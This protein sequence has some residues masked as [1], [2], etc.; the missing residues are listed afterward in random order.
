MMR[1]PVHRLFFKHPVSR[2][3]AP[4]LENIAPIYYHFGGISQIV[5]KK[6]NFGT[7]RLKIME[8]EEEGT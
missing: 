2:G 7:I 6:L 3:I 4:K 1:L 8:H 5:P